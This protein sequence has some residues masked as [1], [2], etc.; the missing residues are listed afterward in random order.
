MEEELHLET[1]SPVPIDP[2]FPLWV[3]HN[4][5]GSFEKVHWFWCALTLPIADLESLL[6]FSL[7]KGKLWESCTITMHIVRAKVHIL[8]CCA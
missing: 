6:H 7:P 1:I 5:F 8:S 4:C 2:G 3:A